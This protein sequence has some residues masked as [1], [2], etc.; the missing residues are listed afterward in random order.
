[1]TYVSEQI[2]RCRKSLLTAAVVVP[3]L[4]SLVVAIVV[5]PVG[6]AAET[7]TI[8]DTTGADAFFGGVAYGEGVFVAAACT[9]GLGNEFMRST[10]GATWTQVSSDSDSCYRSITYGNGRFVALGMYDHKVTTSIDGGLTWTTTCP[11]DDACAAEGA[12]YNS[13]V[14]GA[15]GFVAVSF[16]PAD[17][18][19]TS[20]DG[21]DWQVRTV[22]SDASTI[23]WRDV[24]YGN[25]RYV[26]V[27]HYGKAMYSVDGINW[28]V[29]DM[30]ASGFYDVTFG[31]G[32]FVAVKNSATTGSNVQTSTDGVTW[33]L[34]DD[35]PGRNWSDITYAQDTFVAVGSSGT[36]DRSMTSAD[37]VTWTLRPTPADNSWA[38]LVEGDGMFVAVASGGT[39]GTYAMTS[40]SLVYPPPTS[41]T[42]TESTTSTSTPSTSTTVAPSTTSTS[43]TAAL[44]TSA[45]PTTT[46]LSPTT[47]PAGSGPTVAELEALTARLAAPSTVTKGQSVA[48]SAGGF[49]PGEPV[50]FLM[51]SEPV[52]LGTAVADASGV[53][54]L[55]VTIPSAATAGAHHLY[56]FGLRSRT[57]AQAPVQVEASAANSTTNS[58]L[59]SNGR[60]GALALTGAG[61]V[62]TLGVA[63]MLLGAGV[64]LVAV[65]R[66]T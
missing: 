34:V 13:I 28:T 54:R 20:P 48:L 42:T 5:G 65:R 40:G 37:G 64:V 56:A 2:R 46:G 17:R 30:A 8:A 61:A 33:T 62:G 24:T 29:S 36:G 7:W 49:E 58:P 53:V 21:L 3:L 39:A 9:A 14:H 57:G 22:T 23:Q 18:V 16:F 66:R 59:A 44:P 38:A 35:V 32:K 19:L 25:G 1:M 15:A 60:S 63:V 51:R 45:A 12:E 26:A 41:S 43:T 11:P 27:S 6:A 50:E 55:T 10:N 4:A 52:L 47:V 31:G